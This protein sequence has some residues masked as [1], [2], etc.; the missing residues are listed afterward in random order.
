MNP[1]TISILGCGWLGLPLATSLVNKGYRV[2][3]STTTVSKIENL[4]E[5]GIIPYEVVIDETLE[6]N[7]DGFLE[8]DILLINVPFR[9]QK[10]FLKQYQELAN[11]LITKGVQKVIFI[12]STSVYPEVDMEISEDFEF[13]VNPAKESLLALEQIFSNNT[14]LQTTVV[15]FAGLIGGT[16]NPGN[17]FKEDNT[18][19]NGLSP[20]NLIHLEDC[21]GII[22]AI[23]DQN[24]W[25][26]IFNAAAD[27]HPSKKS[28][29]TAARQQMGL[30]PANFIEELNSFKIISNHKV[31]SLLNYEFQ[32][33]DLLEGLKTF[34]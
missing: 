28:Y 16:R 23:I 33:P 5:N 6:G 14:A 31:K 30:P 12:S 11:R 22:E 4:L 24:Q 8:T 10:S 9:K 20:I 21:I 7:I 32:F 26:N 34:S 2:K 25:N 29:Y 27:S 18:V 19:A 15:R 13:E 3:G 1:T 17:F